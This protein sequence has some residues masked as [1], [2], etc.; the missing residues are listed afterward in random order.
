MLNYS[1]LHARV[2]N[3]STV[4]QR[5]CAKPN[6]PTIGSAVFAA[7]TRETNRYTSAVYVNTKS[8]YNK[9]PKNV[10]VDSSL[11]LC[12]IAKPLMRCVRQ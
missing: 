12:I 9:W 6:W 10:S 5:V 8:L 11:I 3:T 7:L 1:T 2:L 4:V